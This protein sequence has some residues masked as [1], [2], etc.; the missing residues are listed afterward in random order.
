MVL[1][2]WIISIV[3]ILPAGRSVHQGAFPTFSPSFALPPSQNQCQTFYSLDVRQLYHYVWFAANFLCLPLAASILNIAFNL[4]RPTNSFYI[5]LL[6]LDFLVVASIS[7]C[8]LCQT[9]R[10][11]CHWISLLNFLMDLMNIG[12][13]YE[14]PS[15][16]GDRNGLSITGGY[17]SKHTFVPCQCFF[18]SCLSFS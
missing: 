6:L 10:K 3:S 15:I 1:S 12:L 9:V 13:L 18:F 11:G 2:R 17:I 16:I 4:N 7:S 8:S 14:T 5:S